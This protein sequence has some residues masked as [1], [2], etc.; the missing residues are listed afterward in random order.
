MKINEKH[1]RAIQNIIRNNAPEEVIKYY[2]D[3]HLHIDG[4]FAVAGFY[5]GVT[6][7]FYAN[8]RHK[9]EIVEALIKES[10]VEMFG[11]G[12]CSPNLVFLDLF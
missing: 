7:L 12:D 5:S 6:A 10:A 3:H 1:G 8:A 11:E 4:E 9:P 2:H